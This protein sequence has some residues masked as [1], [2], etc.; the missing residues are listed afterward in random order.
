M[1]GLSYD[2]RL[3]ELRPRTP[4][5]GTDGQT[6]STQP[7]DMNVTFS[8]FGWGNLKQRRSSLKTEFD[9]GVNFEKYWVA[10]RPSY[11]TMILSSK[12]PIFA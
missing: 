4:F 3:V 2:T 6:H 8:R 12:D 9:C 5:L 7:W 11:L 1:I 10:L